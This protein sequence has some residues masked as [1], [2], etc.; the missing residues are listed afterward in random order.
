MAPVGT[1]REAIDILANAG[2]EALKADEV[3][4]GLRTLGIDIVDGS[5]AAFAQHIDQKMSWSTVVA[6]SA[7]RN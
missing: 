7:W 5:P 2:N 6:S 1:P 3:I 4:N